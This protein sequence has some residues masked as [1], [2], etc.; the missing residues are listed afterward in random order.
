[1]S[2]GIA[3]ASLLL[4]LARGQQVG[5]LTAEVHPALTWQTCTAPGVCTTTSGKVVL[6]ANWRWLHSTSG[7]TN[8]YTGNTWDVSNSISSYIF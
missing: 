3:I 5:T 8:C 7:S 2:Y 4:G 1:M 6:D